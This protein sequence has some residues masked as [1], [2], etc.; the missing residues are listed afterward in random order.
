MR[1]LQ[2]ADN[3]IGQTA[4][5]RIDAETGLNARGLDFLN[6]FKNIADT[7]I[8]QRVDVLLIIGDLFTRVSPHP[9][10]ILEVIREL[11]QV[12]RAGITSIIVGGN[13]ETPRIET[14]LN[15]L[16]FLGEI[17]GVRL[18]IDPGTAN[19]N[20]HDF[21]CVPAPPNFNDIHMLFEPLLTKALA[22]SKSEKKILASHIPL[23]QA[24]T[25]SEVMLE[26]FIGENVDVG[27]I[28]PKFEYVAL[29]HMHK[30]QRIE[31][32]KMPI[33]YSGSS[34]RYEFNEERDDKY[35]LLL[36]FGSAL[37]VAPI[38]LATRRMLTIVEA[39]CSGLSAVKITRL[40]LNAIETNKQDVAG[41]LVRIKLDGIDVSQNRFIDWNSIKASLSESGVF[42]TKI[43]AR[44][45]VSL[46]ELGRTPG[47]YI[48]PPSR[49][50][51]FYLKGKKEYHD[52]LQLLLKLGNEVISENRE[53]ATAEA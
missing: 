23:A 14:T 8:K 18:F 7:A 50:L 30:F 15:P 10:Y 32:D 36:D 22:S 20:G 25:S 1:V 6:S 48:F 11:K 46:P 27:Q 31:S 49:E 45:E 17:D 29:G 40:V 4:Y 3:H 51:E 44:T 41:S 24:M 9:K 33:Y 34:E 16:S 5:A 35:A 37:N 43:Q 19:V 38:K 26:T 12:T 21:V 42:E 13:H 53:V 28:P 39:N 47:Q 2:T 52:K